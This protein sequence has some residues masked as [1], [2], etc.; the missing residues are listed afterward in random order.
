MTG[1]TRWWE[2]GRTAL[3]Q[4]PRGFCTWC[5]ERDPLLARLT[6][7]PV[8]EAAK[9]VGGDT[10]GKVWTSALSSP[11]GMTRSAVPAWKALDA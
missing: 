5:K 7:S 2:N 3:G 11:H 10:I 8:G 1:E 6:R 4:A 9:L